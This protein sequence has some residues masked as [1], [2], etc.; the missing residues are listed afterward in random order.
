MSDIVGSILSSVRIHI[1]F[2]DKIK[3]SENMFRLIFTRRSFYVS[4]TFGF[5]LV[6]NSCFLSFEQ[7]VFVNFVIAIDNNSDMGL[8]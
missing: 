1:S 8:V 6:V 4:P 7:Y 5:E 3:L 2:I